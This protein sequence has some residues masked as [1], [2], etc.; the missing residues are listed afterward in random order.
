[1]QLTESYYKLLKEKT[2]GI[3]YR[4]TYERSDI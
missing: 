1:M 3:F 2:N 4:K